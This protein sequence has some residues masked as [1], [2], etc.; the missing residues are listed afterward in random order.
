MSAQ[1]EPDMLFHNAKGTTKITAIETEAEPLPR[2]I[3]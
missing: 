1:L 3:W 2:K